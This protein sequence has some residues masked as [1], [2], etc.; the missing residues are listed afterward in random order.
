M[1]SLQQEAF[2]ALGVHHSASHSGSKAGDVNARVEKEFA[3]LLSQDK[4]CFDSEYEQCL[5]SR[6]FEYKQGSAPIV[7]KDRLRSKVDFWVSIGSS[8]WVLY[9][10]RF[11]YR[12]PFIS[13]PPRAFFCNNRSALDHASFV[14]SAISDLLLAGS[15]I[16]VFTPPTVVNP[17]TVSVNSVGKR[18]LILDLRHVNKF[19]PKVKFKMEDSRTFLNYVHSP[20]YVFKFDMKS[21]YHHVS[22]HE[23]S[24]TFLGFQWPLGSSVEP[25]FFVFAVL[26]FGLSSAPY[27]F[28]KVFRPLVKHWRSRG[29]PLVLYLDDGAG[30]LHDF[31]VAQSTASAVRSDLANAGVVANEEKSIWVP[32]QVLEWLGIVWDLSRGRIFIPHRRIVKLLR[33]LLSLKSGS[34]SV[35]PRAVASVT[36][37][38][39]SLTPGYG[40]ITLLMSRFLQSFVKLHSGWDCPLDFRSYQF[41][42]EC[43]QEIDFWLSNC[44]RLNGR[45]LT[46]YSLP[47]TLVYSD[48]SSFACGGCAFRVDSEEFDLF[49]QAFSSLESGL[50]SNA[51]ELLAILYGLKSFRASLTGKVVKVF[52]D[53]KNAASISAKGSN[54]LRLHA[55]ALEIFAY[56]AA[57]DISLEVEWIPRSLNSYADSVSRVVD[58]DDWAVS[59]IF[60]QHVSSIFVLLTSIVSHPLFPL[61]ASVFTL[62]SGVPVAKA[63]T[64]LVPVGAALTTIWFLQSFL[65]RV[66]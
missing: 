46:R 18:R 17:L 27:V 33:A 54:S 36:G 38:I 5:S 1:A 24:Q 29:I 15:V 13:W 35:T 64:L 50:D 31:S 23:E 40:N 26:P 41:F 20:G 2:G 65:S 39:I 45:S 6:G 34:R 57:H 66:S 28:T 59:T 43:L 8:P 10:I 12:I 49:F 60:F 51:R 14:D 55:L 58:Y 52:T 7:Y 4:Y 53:S 9:I 16:E 44:A 47:V 22:I 25:R 42:S 21:G 3:D 30:C 32:T 37:Q 19:I 56:C 61:S 11:G 48:A 62:S 63:W